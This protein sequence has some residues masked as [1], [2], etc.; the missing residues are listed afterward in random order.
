MST[1][2]SLTR[3][4]RAALGL[5]AVA[6]LALSACA[7]PEAAPQP[8]PTVTTASALPPMD[9]APFTV[10]VPSL[11]LDRVPDA[12]I[13]VAEGTDP[14]HHG[15]WLL[16]PGAPEWTDAMASA[17]RA[18]IEQYRRDTDTS[19]DPRLKVQPH[20]AVVGEDIAAARLLS[21]ETRGA[22]SVSSAHVVWYSAREDRVLEAADLFTPEGWD[23]FRSEVRQRMENDPDVVGERL[24]SAVDAPDQV[25]NRR[26]W[27]AVVFLPDGSVLLEADQ[28]SMAPAAAGVLT[29]RIPRDTAAPWL[30]DLGQ[31]AAE[32]A[33]TPADLRLPD[34]STPTPAPSDPVESSWT[35]E[36][37][38]APVPPRVPVTPPPP[39]TTP[40]SSWTP[41]ATGA[42]VPPR[43]PV[44]PPPAPSS[45]EPP[46]TS[47][48]P[49]SP[50]PSTP[51]PT[52]SSPG[53]PTPSSPTP[54]PSPSTSTPA[55]SP[56][57]SPSTS[58]PAPSTPVPSP[59]S[60]STTAPPAPPSPSTTPTGTPTP[61][62]S[63][64]EPSVTT[65]SGPGAPGNPSAPGVPGVPGPPTD[66]SVP[67]PPT[68]AP[69]DGDV[70]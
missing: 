22:D 37:T 15:A 13:A 14:E 3:R 4:R 23:A 11:D 63:S 40:E 6:V 29:V 56:S 8:S 59:S 68:G 33:R 36:T 44:T 31:A 43:V 21:T 52:T 9:M 7:G 55:P 54:S 65:A 28:A 47:A 58:T 62:P 24:A 41:E 20:L 48:A 35:P 5:A 49:T 61:G 18:Q 46:S 27:D 39:P 25:E 19:A 26:I 16:V 70:A 50:S 34:R 67:G 45:T 2:A 60:P 51:A 64:P 53:S 66:R 32:A 42:P 38:G 12:S 1:T 17:V 30:S 10:D 69:T 57:P